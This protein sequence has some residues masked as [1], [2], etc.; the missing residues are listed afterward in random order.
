[1]GSSS[2][3]A[4]G[5][6]RLAA[7]DNTIYWTEN[8]PDP[9]G[10][11]QIVAAS[12]RGKLAVV[13]G[14]P[15][16]PAQL[17]GLA[18]TAAQ[19][20]W[21]DGAALRAARCDGGVAGA[22]GD[23]VTLEGQGL[24][25]VTCVTADRDAAFVARAGA[26]LGGA[27]GSVIGRVEGGRVEDLIAL[28]GTIDQLIVA[29][30][31]LAWTLHGAGDIYVKGTGGS[32]LVFS[33]HEPFALCAAGTEHLVVAV[34]ATL[35]RVE[36]A[37][38]ESVQLAEGL[39]P[40]WPHAV[41]WHAGVAYVARHEVVHGNARLGGCIERVDLAD[42]TATIVHARATDA[43][44]DQLVAND[45]GAFCVERTRDDASVAI[46]H[47]TP[48][49][50]ERVTIEKRGSRTG[51]GIRIDSAYGKLRVGFVGEVTS[52]AELVKRIASEAP[53]RL[54]L[55][56]APASPGELLSSACGHHQFGS[57]TALV[58]PN[59]GD[60][61]LGQL[62]DLFGAFPAVERTYIA[63]GLALE[64]FEHAVMRELH[65]E[66]DHL[67]PT[68][69]KALAG[70]QL[71]ALE[72]CALAFKRI[73]TAALLKLVDAVAAI[74]APALREV[75]FGGLRGLD[76]IRD[77]INLLTNRRTPVAWELVSFGGSL[78]GEDTWLDLAD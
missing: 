8:Q 51:G 26:P 28:A 59:T 77:V 75:H 68:F 74:A 17:R 20:V 19:L 55:L 30:R 32:A 43:A 14:I 49:P 5:G 54:D 29:G 70:S 38:G 24:A 47:V 60:G 73:S 18:A 12:Q 2:Y 3:T 71:P 25:W 42:N 22:G 64:P 33:A 11:Q 13:R 31:Y 67:K 37:T 27:Q 66:S 40:G 65:L 44:I 61:S 41:A 46:V 50:V 76:Q 1:M 58:G 39:A 69:A 72:R 36:L 48:E 9:A 10:L 16:P 63:G 4:V 35:V 57:V 78:A 7:R 21:H 62:A 6:G 56:C 34:G 52:C 23:V 15:L 45:H 53:R